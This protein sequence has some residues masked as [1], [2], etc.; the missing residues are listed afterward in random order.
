MVLAGGTRVNESRL[1]AGGTRVDCFKRGSGR[2]SLIKK[3]KRKKEKK[4]K[5]KRKAKRA[6]FARD[7]PRKSNRTKSRQIIPSVAAGLI[8]ND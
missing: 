3:K 1:L 6:Q 5:G 7:F 2:V 8:D 4:K